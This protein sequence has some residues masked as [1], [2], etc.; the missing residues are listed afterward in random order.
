MKKSQIFLYSC[1]AFILGLGLRSFFDI[2]LFVVYVLLVFGL[3]VL[4]F[5]VRARKL[6]VL[7]IVILGLGAGMLRYNLSVKEVDET[8]I[9]FYNDKEVISFVGVV[10]GEPD[11]RVDQVKLKVEVI[12]MTGGPAYAPFDPAQ[13]ATAGKV[14]V[15]TGLYPKFEYGDELEIRCEL[16]TPVKFEDFDYERY[17]ARYDIYSVCYWPQIRLLSQGNGN[18]IY[19]GILR[20]KE[21]LKGV[22]E[23]GL[24]EPGAGILNAVALGSRRGIS[25]ELREKFSRVGISHIMAISGLHI[26]LLAGI[27][28]SLLIRIGF[29]RK[30][31]FWLGTGFLVLYIIMIGAPASAVRAGIMGFLLMLGMNMGRVSKSVN[32]LLLVACLMLLANPRILRDDVGFQ[33]SFLAVLGII[34]FS[35]LFTKWFKK[36]P[37]KFGIRDVL[38]MTFSAQVL[39]LPLIAY[40]FGRV[41]IVSPLVNIFVLPILPLVLIFGFLGMIFGLVWIGLAKILFILIFILLGYLVKVVEIFSRIPFAGIEISHAPVWVI[42]VVYLVIGVVIWRMG[43]MIDDC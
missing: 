23:R 25:E 19:A 5:T 8:K 41:S 12:R 16:K 10:A 7:G 17:L 24:P 3:V 39:V 36:I 22:V 9:Q 43:R 37:E 34:Y 15:T 11:R 6:M 20:V 30:Q 27:L 18:R 33:L 29:W 13:G 31:A 38:V 28:M 42:G 14:L 21:K 32:S 35:P 2:S 1:I 26:T 40:H 4:I